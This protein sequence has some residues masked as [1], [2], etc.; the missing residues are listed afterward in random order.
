MN[1][2][3]RLGLETSFFY[4]LPN[5]LICVLVVLI[6]GS[7]AKLPRNYKLLL[8]VHCC[9]PF[10]LND[11]LFSASYMGDQFRYTGAVREIRESFELTSEIGNVANASW[12]LAF[13]PL[14]FVE[15]IKS[16]GFFNKLIFVLMFIFLYKKGVL[17]R[18]SAYFLLLYPSILLYT[19]LS[20]RDTVIFSCM[21]LTA[22]FAVKRN[23]LLMVLFIAPL[24]FIKFQNFFIMLPLFT[25]LL[26]NLGEKGLSLRKGLVILVITF[27][28]LI[29]SFPVAAPLINNLRL[30]M[31]REDG[32]I[33]VGDVALINGIGDFIYMGIT[34]GLYFF[35]KPLPWEASKVLQ[36]IQSLENIVIMIIVIKLTIHAWRKNMN[37][38]M[39]WLVLFVASLS[40]YGLVVFNY[41]TAARYRFSFIALYV[42][43]VAY[44]CN[45]TQLFNRKIKA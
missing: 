34:S 7:L 33:N 41:G 3:Q 45:I 29:I 30:A 13:I 26:F 14:P 9:M 2:Y 44:V 10:F 16:L 23:F 27:I 17:T 42:V 11:F 38:L 24:Y 19:G 8:L 40:I 18:F 20:I 22:Y 37:K 43:Y 32:G 28:V 1:W 4:D 15:T 35:V 21:M 39:F 36:L 6:A 25:F 12:I 5:F 31:F